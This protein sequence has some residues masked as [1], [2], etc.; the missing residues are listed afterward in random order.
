MSLR[1][2]EASDNQI[3]ARR[4]AASSVGDPIIKTATV[5][6]IGASLLAVSPVQAA[7][8]H[9][10]HAANSHQPNLALD[11]VPG[12]SPSDDQ[13]KRVPELVTEYFADVDSGK[14]EEAYALHG[15][16]LARKYPLDDFSQLET[17]FN[18][19]A[20]PIQ[21]RRILKIIWAKDPTG[22]DSPGVY[23]TV[24]FAARFANVDRYC[25]RLVLQARPDEDFKIVREDETYLAN[26]NAAAI[27]AKGS[28]A[29][30]NAAWNAASRHCPN[31]REL[32][33]KTAPPSSGP[34]PT[35]EAASPSEPSLA[36]KPPPAPAPFPYSSSPP[37]PE[38]GSAPEPSPSPG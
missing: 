10:G 18:Q 15:D 7:R 1:P 33:T 26:S 20:G 24:D 38:V 30:V 25:G 22:A 36:S 34:S 8:A 19:M 3:A 27:E 23:V 16:D 2:I 14:Y 32:P 28:R 21:E 37:S 12:W 5:L 11:S 4:R 9:K 6:L 29:T 13:R 35:Q 31:Y 17:A